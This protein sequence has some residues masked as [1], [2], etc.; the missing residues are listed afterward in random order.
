MSPC[1][2][3]YAGT[4][5]GQEGRS[6]QG[7]FVATG[8]KYLHTVPDYSTSSLPSTTTITTTT[9]LP[10]VQSSPPPLPPYP[11]TVVAFSV[12]ALASILSP[13]LASPLPPP[14]HAQTL[15]THARTADPSVQQQRAEYEPR[16]EA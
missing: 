12:A 8:C 6:R 9:T 1:S 10:P 5:R 7:S 4:P 13:L 2:A 15:A 11:T 3:D 16:W 14:E